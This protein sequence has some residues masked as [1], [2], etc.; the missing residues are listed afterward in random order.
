M[1]KKNNLSVIG[2]VVGMKYLNC[3]SEYVV[4]LKLSVAWLMLFVIYILIKIVL[5]FFLQFAG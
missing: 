3:V 5:Y 4:R 2:E 1:K